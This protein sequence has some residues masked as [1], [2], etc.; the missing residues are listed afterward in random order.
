MPLWLKINLLNFTTISSFFIMIWWSVYP[1]L[2]SYINW[3]CPAARSRTWLLR[4]PIVECEALRHAA[5]ESEAPHLHLERARDCEGSSRTAWC[6]DYWRGESLARGWW[7]R[8]SKKSNK[9]SKP[10]GMYENKYFGY[11]N[12]ASIF[13][14]LDVT[15]CTGHSAECT[16]RNSHLLEFLGY[17]FS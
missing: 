5:A 17:L 15:F 3:C 1:N 8:K 11:L 13:I 12:S 6:T 2:D 16:S 7:W 9:P 14:A 10:P 4:R